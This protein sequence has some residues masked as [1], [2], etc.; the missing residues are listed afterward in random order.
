MENN[1]NKKNILILYPGY[2]PGYKYGGPT[3]SLMNLCEKMGDEYNFFILTTDHDLGSDKSY[4][5]ININAWNDIGKAKVYYCTKNEL[6]ITGF[7]KL[8]NSISYDFLYLNSFFSYSFSIRP[9]L[10]WKFGLIEKKPLIIAPRGQLSKGSLSLKASKKSLYIW[11]SKLLSLYKGVQWQSSSKHETDDIRRIFPDAKVLLAPNLLGRSLETHSCEVQSRET[12]R[13]LFLSRISPEKNLLFA[14]EV[15]E[16]VRGRFIFDIY[17]PIGDK[18]YWKKCKSAISSLPG[19]VQV[20]YKGTVPFERTYQTMSEYDILF[21]PSLGENFGHVF[22][23]ALSVGTPILTSN[24]TRWR[25]LESKGIGWDLDLSN[26]NLFRRSLNILSKMTD[27][28]LCQMR[29]NSHEYARKFSETDKSIK[30][31]R[32]LFSEVKAG[33]GKD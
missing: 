23:E 24:R 26:M 30:I 22:A 19:N 6:A 32:E 7:T 10:L 20:C 2:Y 18:Q 27:E 8:I 31:Y 9:F 14:L 25:E 4:D 21:V 28:E 3:R 13:V 1:Q 11:F 33:E 12:S 15:M 29:Q 16:E 17:G 5:S